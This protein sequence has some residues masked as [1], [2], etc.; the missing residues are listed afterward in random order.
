MEPVRGA[1]DEVGWRGSSK[2]FRSANKGEKKG[3]LVM[4]WEGDEAKGSEEEG[5]GRG[6]II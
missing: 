3:V 4:K 1:R 6:E 5:V 2:V